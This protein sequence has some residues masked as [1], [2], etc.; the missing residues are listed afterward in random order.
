MHNVYYTK[1]DNNTFQKQSNNIYYQG[2]CIYPKTWLAFVRALELL[3]YTNTNLVFGHYTPKK[4][5]CFRQILGWCFWVFL[6]RKE[7][8]MHNVYLYKNT[9]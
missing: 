1:T 6:Y 2:C 7:S 5:V 4:I 3:D 9:Q 8:I